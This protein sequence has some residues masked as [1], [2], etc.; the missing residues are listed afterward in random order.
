VQ[1]N[2]Y[3]EWAVTI[4]ITGGGVGDVVG[5]SEY[6]EE[7][8]GGNLILQEVTADAIVMLEQLTYGQETCA[9]NGTI[10]LSGID[11]VAVTFAWSGI[12]P[13][14]T[15]SSAGG[16]LYRPDSATLP[17][18]STTTSP[19]PAD[20]GSA[21]QSG[22]PGGDGPPPN[23]TTQLNP[24]Y[25][26]TFSGTGNQTD[27]DNVWPIT[28]TFIGGRPGEVIGTVEY[29]TLGCGGELILVSINQFDEWGGFQVIERITYGHEN[30]IDGGTFWFST[31]ESGIG[32]TFGWE[33]PTSATRA[34]G[35]LPEVA[36]GAS[37][38]A[39]PA[40]EP[41]G[42]DATD[43][44]PPSIYDDPGAEPVPIEAEDGG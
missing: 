36:P 24:N 12:G 42:E 37:A 33:S 41:A 17:G 38:P 20:S 3:G 16:L 32:I 5:T 2:P 11:N 19:A 40:A 7:V 14:G 28:V 25:I 35:H 6:P 18:D 26:G 10:T 15:P 44:G 9:D 31:A 34:S 4:A 43:G 22:Y 39:A 29:P 1:E 23:D 27:P 21:A 8:C 30:C 13:Y